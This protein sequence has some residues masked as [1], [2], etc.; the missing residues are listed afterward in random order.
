MICL[1]PATIAQTLTGQPPPGFEAMAE[2]NR[3]LIDIVY[4]GRVIA[5]SLASFDQTT[6]TFEDPSG[7]AAIL[8]N[9]RDTE[10]IEEALSK[11][12]ETNAG[13]LCS[14]SDAGPGCGIVQP[15]D[16]AI[17]FD[18]ANLRAELFINP[19]Y[20]VQIDPRY[21]FLP[22]PTISPGLLS[23]FNTRTAYDHENDRFVGNHT[24][25]AIAGRGR[26]ALRGDGF[27][28]ASGSGQVT[29]MYATHSGE[30]RAWS[31]G[32]MPPQAS[33]GLARSWRLFGVRF[34]TL[35]DSR[36]DRDQLNATPIEVSVSQSAT[37]ELQRDG[38]TL[39]VQQIEPGQTQIET[40]RLPA[41]SYSLDLLINEGG[42]T[43]TE[44]RFFSTNSQLPPQNAPR[45]YVELGNAV[46]LRR[47]S[48]G[49]E[50][51]DP[52]AIAF[53]WAQRVG[54]NWGVRADG[55]FGSEVSFAEVATS[56]RAAGWT[57]DLALTG[58]DQGA[59]GLSISGST[60][61]LGW[62]V[63]GS[64]RDLDPGETDPSLSSDVYSPFPDGFR[65]A[66]LSLN[67]QLKIGR[68]G[69]RGFYRE[70]A[71]GESFWFAGPYADLSVLERDK[72]RLN[73]NA[74]AEL[75]AETNALF[76]GV[77]LARSFGARDQFRSTTR[78]DSFSQRDRATD[79]LTT[80]S[81]QETEL[82]LT[83]S[84]RRSV[85]SALFASVRHDEDWGM[86]I[87]G[88]YRAPWVN[89]RV[90]G[91]NN[92]QNQNTVLLGLS[93]GLIVDQDGV[94]ISDR[95]SDAGVRVS[96]DGVRDA[97]VAVLVNGVTRAVTQTGQST[98]VPLQAYAIADIAIQPSV[99]EDLAYDQSTD[100]FVVYPG[101]VMRVRRSVRRVTIFVGRLVLSDGTVLANATIRTGDAVSRTDSGG[102]FQIDGT[103]G[104][105]LTVESSDGATC[106]VT[107]PDHAPTD[108]AFVD[109][110]QLECL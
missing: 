4:R 24:I 16:V 26:M 19:R 30:D 10:I 13:L 103:I 1:V 87:G 64:Y 60:D 81:R 96:V 22:P 66:D 28:D 27:A 71:A 65:Q 94:S 3:T 18:V 98:F 68:I 42:V 23:R 29:A 70:N 46:P 36:L 89:A 37:I 49:F 38:Q 7:L 72:W 76:L 80:Q 6:L 9:V 20:S 54:P 73:F 40:G 61:M 85:N 105:T 59:F 14:N 83:Q 90:D 56:V 86:R 63:R 62:Q 39:D 109:L 91:R 11:P 35:T 12:L 50:D 48:D 52:P 17:I 21:Q 92:Y 33:P 2:T 51:T 77:G 97:Q 107:I 15:R 47:R 108:S 84:H 78:V 58:S 110:G 101:N 8:P 93:S 44:T 102:Y 69:A 32:L 100:R 53:G 45:W 82:R 67:R 31:A 106:E 43:R 55:F 5:V 57:G 25:R 88:S 99:A 104:Q 75:G 41:G 74:R 34:G 79:S 95:S